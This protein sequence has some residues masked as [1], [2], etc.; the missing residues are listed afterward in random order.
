[1]AILERTQHVDIL[2]TRK[3]LRSDSSLIAVAVRAMRGAVRAAAAFRGGSDGRA[4][5]KTCL[6]CCGM[7]MCSVDK[8]RPHAR[9]SATAHFHIM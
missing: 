6:G 4:V 1:M 2:E 5:G 8:M 9:D 3:T 7:S